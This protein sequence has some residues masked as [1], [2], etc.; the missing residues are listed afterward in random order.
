MN[1]T[2]NKSQYRAI[3][4]IFVLQEE[5]ADITR[6]GEEETDKVPKQLEQKIKQQQTKN[7]LPGQRGLQ[8]P[9]TTP[10]TWSPPE[11]GQQW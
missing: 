11:R 7:F 6:K 10:G 2:E 8:V 5:A 3:I 9:G 1:I 4:I